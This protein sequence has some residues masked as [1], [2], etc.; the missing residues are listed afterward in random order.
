M[1]IDEYRAHPALN[2]SLAKLLAF[3][4]PAHFQQAKEE[5]E[6]LDSIAIR[7]GT[8]VHDLL[9]GISRDFAIKPAHREDD[10]ADAWHGSKKWCKEWTAAQT[11]PIF[12]QEEYDNVMGMRLALEDDPIF[13]TVMQLCPVRETPVL[14]EYRGVPIKALPDMLGYDSQGRRMIIDLK[15]TADA[16][17]AE[18]SRK[19]RKLGYHIQRQ[20]YTQAVS[21]AEG[22]EE[23]PVYMLLAVESSKP[24]LVKPYVFPDEAIEEGQRQMDK[25]I[26]LH[27]QCTETGVWPGYPAAPENLLWPK[28]KD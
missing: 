1:T 18:F 5:P 7:M 10:P 9:Q 13:Q 14:A 24:Y 6:E 26:D 3:K 17:P 2:F 4:T 8:A 22:L 15:T 27:K 19:C 20:W 25:I 28:W 11:L 16:S 12:T 23:E 21:L